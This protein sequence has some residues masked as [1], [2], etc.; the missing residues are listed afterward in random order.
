MTDFTNHDEYEINEKDIDSAL[1]YLRIFDP[2]HATPE[3]AIAFLEYLRMG[4]HQKAHESTDEELEAL[5]KKFKKQ[6]SK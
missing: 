1:N 6:D 5:Y 2:E 3:H 4:V